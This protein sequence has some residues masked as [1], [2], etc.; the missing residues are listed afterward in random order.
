[1]PWWPLKQ[2]CNKATAMTSGPHTCSG[3]VMSQADEVP[4]RC[5]IAS[6]GPESWR[7]AA[8][9]MLIAECSPYGNGQVLQQGGPKKGSPF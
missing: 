9:S 4:L 2:I 8:V 1:M 6:K 7:K 5:S 3:S